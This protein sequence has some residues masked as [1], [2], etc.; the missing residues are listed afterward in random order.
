MKKQTYVTFT[1]ESGADL[2]KLSLRQ[3]DAEMESGVVV[4]TLGEW[5][6]A[7]DYV[8]AK[9]PPRAMAESDLIELVKKQ[10]LLWAVEEDEDNA[11]QDP[12]KD[13]TVETRHAEH[14]A[15]FIAALQGV[16]L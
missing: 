15:S 16:S 12:D 2:Q 3:V 9:T 5:Q 8:A 14:F 4:L 11:E 13:V 10:C 6:D 1:N 7:V